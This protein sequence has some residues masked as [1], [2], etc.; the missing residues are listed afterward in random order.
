MYGITKILSEEYQALISAF[1][2]LKEDELQLKWDFIESCVLQE[3]QR[4]I[5][6][7]DSSLVESE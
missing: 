4:I 5:S 1:D 7:F 2:A 3:E 6:R